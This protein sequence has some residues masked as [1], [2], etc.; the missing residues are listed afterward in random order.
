MI[1]PLPAW[2]EIDQ[3]LELAALKPLME[4]WN[5]SHKGAIKQFSIIPLHPDPSDQSMTDANFVFR[6][7]VAWLMKAN[8]YANPENISVL[9][10][11]D[12][13]GRR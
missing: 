9:N 5:W 11:S 12:L 7:S 3:P 13:R 8:K 4:C 10:L 1:L 6:S 2:G